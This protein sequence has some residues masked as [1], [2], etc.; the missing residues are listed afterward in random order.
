MKDLIKKL[1]EGDEA[2]F[3]ELT[4]KLQ[5]D[6]YRIAKTRLQNEDDIHDAIQNT[7]IITYNNVKKIRNED[8]FRYWMI[9]VLIN[10]C[11]KIYNYNKKNIETCNRI[12]TENKYE[13][14]S[15][16]MYDINSK[17]DFDSLLEKINYDEKI[18]LTLHYS[19]QYS[20]SQIAKLL[21]LNVNTVK[22]RLNRGKEKLREYYKEVNYE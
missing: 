22:S 16:P 13:D 1:K 11:N 5:N 12:L 14:F 18:V 21:N 19:S 4:I 15:N 2:A 3:K 17:L 20:C 6:L 10:E 9:H 8:S 7:M